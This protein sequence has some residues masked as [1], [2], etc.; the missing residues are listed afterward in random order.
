MNIVAR[1]AILFGEVQASHAIGSFSTLC[2]FLLLASNYSMIAC[3]Y[4][5]YA[6]Q[7]C[8]S[9][10]CI[11]NNSFFHSIGTN[12]LLLHTWSQECK[13]FTKLRALNLRKRL[14]RN[15]HPF[16]ESLIKFVP[17]EFLGL[18]R[19]SALCEIYSIIYR[20]IPRCSL[21]SLLNPSI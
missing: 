9:L 10:S 15:Y 12:Q 3:S 21:P 16:H 5:K 17:C 1:N 11:L 4:P 13:Q 19:A 2:S 8:S 20:F 18:L 14:V 7:A 6:C